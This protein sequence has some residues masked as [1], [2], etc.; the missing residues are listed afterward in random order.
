MA[1]ALQRKQAAR[2]ESVVEEADVIL[3]PDLFVAEV[4]NTIWKLHQFEQ[5]SLDVCDR[6]LKAALGLAD[7]FVPSMELHA[8][9]F[10]LARTARRPAYDMFYLALARRE[11]ATLLTMDTQLRK[12][13]L[14]QG[15]RAV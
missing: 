10:L 9:A 3:A 6:A 1:I 11:D 13:A 5:W 2:L 7:V 14:R 12:E 15:V 4:V 8:E